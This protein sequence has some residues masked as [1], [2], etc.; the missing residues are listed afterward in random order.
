MLK[1]QSLEAAP[2]FPT[3]VANRFGLWVVLLKPVIT[4]GGQ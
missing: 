4:G 3:M 1:K 2:P